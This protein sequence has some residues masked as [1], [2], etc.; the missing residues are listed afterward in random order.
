MDRNFRNNYRGG[1]ND[2]RFNDFSQGHFNHPYQIP[3]DRGHHY[4]ENKYLP[5]HAPQYFPDNRSY[6]LQMPEKYANKGL[7]HQ[8]P[9]KYAN[10][11]LPHQIPELN[12]PNVASS[13]VQRPQHAPEY[14]ADNRYLPHQTPGRYTD[15]MMHVPHQMPKEYAEKGL[16]HQIPEPTI[17]AVAPPPVQYLLQRI[18]CEICD[19]SFPRKNLKEHNNGKKHRGILELRE[20]STKHK[21][22]NGQY[23]RFR[24][25]ELPNEGSKRKH[26]DNTC[27]K[28]CGLMAKNVS[29]DDARSLEYKKVPTER[30]E[31]KNR[32]NTGTKD[33][34]LKEENVNYEAPSYKDVPA[35]R[36][37]R[38]LGDNTGALDHSFKE[39]NVS[40]D[41]PSSEVPTERSERKNSDNTCAKDHGFEVGNA[42]HEA[43]SYKK[44]KAERF[45]RKFRDNIGAK[46]HGFKQRIGGGTGG[47]YMK[48]N[49]G[50]RRP[51]KS[52]KP[53]VNDLSN[54]VKS[55]VQIPELTPP[56]GHVA[57]PIVAPISVE[58]SSFEPQFQHVSDSPTQESKGK[59]H[60]EL[61]DTTMEMN[62]QQQSTPVELSASASFN[63][64]AE[65]EYMNC[66]FA[67]IAMPEGKEHDEIQNFA[68]ETN[69]QLQSISTEL[70]ASAGSNISTV[71]EDKCSDP[72]ALLIASP[73]GPVTSQVF[74]PSPTVGSS[75][76]PKIQI[77]SQT[78][79]AESEEHP[80][81]QNCG[82]ETNDHSLAGSNTNSPIE[83]TCSDSGA[84][85]I[86]PP[87]S[88]IASQVS[89]PE[90]VAVVSSF[91]PKSRQIIQTE[92]SED[93]VHNE[94]QNHTVDSNDQQQSISMES[95]TPAGSVNSDSAAIEL[96]IEPLAFKPP[97]AAESSF[98][99]PLAFE[100]IACSESQIPTDET[101]IQPLALVL[102]EKAPS[103][104][105]PQADLEMPVSDTELGIAQIPQVPVCLKCGDEGFVETLVYCKK[106]E[107]VSL[108]RY[109]LDGPVVFTDEVIWFCEDCEV[110]EVHTAYPDQCTLPLPSRMNNAAVDSSEDRVTAVAPQPVADPIWRGSLKLYNPRLDDTV[111]R[112]MGHLSTLA[113]PK[114]LEKAR[115]LPN[116]L[117]PD[118]LQRSA[119]WPESFKKYG[120][121][122]QSIAIYF[123]PQNERISIKILLVGN[124]Q[125]KA[126]IK[127]KT[128]DA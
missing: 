106:C 31:R 109:C 56:S 51:M 3:N 107:D 20:Q 127:S 119:V 66:D 98:E 19:V 104:E 72:A 42:S 91:E 96:V 87:Q 67:P 103:D 126:S 88:P 49:N 52:S 79:V 70:H 90:A 83:D 18:H 34:G 111:T 113:C 121:N 4:A 89:I 21:T 93:E 81:V 26:R 1:W 23:S 123:F 110:K 47:K 71:A 10:K 74:T 101:D 108:H 27:A 13:S 128:N 28:V 22:S 30:F 54:S 78:E 6:P 36:S 17:P 112:L 48:M 25:K 125:K 85:V 84:I 37:K 118:L 43:P 32:D 73:Q 38:K 29:D 15:K 2:M 24:Y 114:V 95:H 124:F 76:E 57:S 68:V 41:A 115:H 39:K 69:D 7:P 100:G 55:P 77:D 8:I 63:I 53:K 58:E 60:H 14:Y 122:N 9:E 80:E 35:E 105:S 44:V 99:P 12:I 50:I 86:A 94:I 61:Q 59:E 92:M 16:P 5:H 75:F 40:Y 116:V 11:G 120:P 45:K 97:H 33:C 117:Y 62:D 102:V 46:D 64:S 65:T 82:V